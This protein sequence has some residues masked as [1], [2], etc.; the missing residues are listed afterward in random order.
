MQLSAEQERAL[1][2]VRRWLE[3]R[4]GVFRLFG[5]AGTG[6]TTIAKKLAEL[7]NGHVTF[8]AFTGKAAHVMQTKGCDDA[9]T[10]HSLIY[11][12]KPK[13]RKRLRE[14][15]EELG[16]LLESGAS[17]NDPR[18]T[19]LE[20][21]ILDETS[22]VKKP[23]FEL[24]RDS[25]IQDSSLIIVDECS[26]VGEEMAHDLMSF[27]VP[28]LVLGD[29][30]QLPPVKSKGYFTNGKPDFMLEQI[31]RQAEES[32]VIRLATMARQQKPITVG[33]YG[34]SKVIRVRDFDNSQ[35]TED[36]I[37]VGKNTTRRRANAKRRACLGRD[38]VLPVI[39]DRLICLRNN[40]ELGL[41]N[42]AMW[43]VE[44]VIDDDLGGMMDV[45]L[46]S[47]DDDRQLL[48]TIHGAPFRGE[49][50]PYWDTE[51]QEFDYGYA[52]TG[53]KAQGSQ[54]PSV[55]LVDESSVFRQDKHRW[56]Y[57]SIT[58]ASERVTIV[59]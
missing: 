37:I 58:R 30:A 9:T 54:W 53:H 42:G 23:S 6:K 5:Y 26:M 20:Q 8:C 49:E 10:I 56:L 18:V 51:A 27:D 1:N 25:K 33:D 24:N 29:P 7:M 50:V 2:A 19:K 35:V 11:R 31:H 32:P 4:S 15:Q 39:G 3:Q 16:E 40:H 28:I 36:Q 21:M 59:R 43:S 52:I 22:S 12:P 55:L 47:E 41:L 17:D 44:D 13:S 34:D 38:S 48:T 57:T 14:L 45:R 46:V